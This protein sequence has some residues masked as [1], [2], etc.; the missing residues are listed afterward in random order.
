MPFAASCL[1]HES[2]L[3]FSSSSVSTLYPLPPH[4]S[5]LVAVRG[6]VG[7]GWGCPSSGVPLVQVM[8]HCLFSGV[9]CAVLENKWDSPVVTPQASRVPVSTLHHG[10][11]GF[12]GLQLKPGCEFPCKATT[13]VHCG[14]S[15]V[16]GRVL[17]LV[18][19]SG[20][21]SQVGSGHVPSRTKEWV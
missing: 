17:W 16:L 18:A 11:P 21:A 7:V 1:G 19:F 5:H 8:H 3:F 4:Y 9:Y 20:T 15:P 2:S 10:L 12:L 13:A 6:G 14:A